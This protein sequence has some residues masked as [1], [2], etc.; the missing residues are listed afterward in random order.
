MRDVTLGLA[1]ALAFFVISS[2]RIQ[3]HQVPIAISYRVLHPGPSLL[4][5][6][7]LGLLAV[8]LRLVSFGG[9]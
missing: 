8:L 9:K 3:T 6:V 1:I 2:V 4:I 7:G 5:G